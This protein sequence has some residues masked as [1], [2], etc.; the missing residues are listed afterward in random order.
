MTTPTTAPHSFLLTEHGHARMAADLPRITNILRNY[1]TKIL[2]TY[3][4]QPLA[5]QLEQNLAH[6]AFWTMEVSEQLLATM[7]A[8]SR[9]TYPNAEWLS[10]YGQEPATPAKDEQLNVNLIPPE[11]VLNRLITS[12][13]W[14]EETTHGEVTIQHLVCPSCGDMN[15]WTLTACPLFIKCTADDCGDHIRIID[16]FPELRGKLKAA[17]TSEST[18]A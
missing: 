14:I 10:S 18:I 8:V 9:A 15:A 11:K 16:L 4:G 2:V 12:P 5:P 3:G 17:P 1:A 13:Y 6:F 7:E